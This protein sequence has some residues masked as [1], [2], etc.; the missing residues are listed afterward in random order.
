MAERHKQFWRVNP[1]PSGGGVKRSDSSPAGA[2]V[3]RRA[4]TEPGKG[5][6]AFFPNDFSKEQADM[7][8][9]VVAEAGRPE[10]LYAQRRDT[11][12]YLRKQCRALFGGESIGNPSAESDYIKYLK[13]NTAVQGRQA[14]VAIYYDG[15]H[16]SP[17][18]VME[19]QRAKRG[20]RIKDA[21]A[22]ESL[23]SYQIARGAVHQWYDMN[24]ESKD[25]DIRGEDFIR[26]LY[27]VNTPKL[28][29][30]AKKSKDYQSFCNDKRLTKEGEEGLL[31]KYKQIL[32][33]AITVAAENGEAF[34]MVTPGAFLY[35]LTPEHQSLAKSIFLDAVVAVAT[36]PSV[37]S[38]NFKGLSVN[39][40]VVKKGDPLAGYLESKLKDAKLCFPVIVNYQDSSALSRAAQ[41]LK[42]DFRCAESVMGEALGCVGNG[43]LGDRANKAFEENLF[44]QAPE[45][46][47]VFSPKF[48]QALQGKDRLVK[49]SVPNFLE[50][51]KAGLSSKI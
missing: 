36:D 42:V 46:V 20:E 45:L 50:S 7:I 14:E 6:T 31:I 1:V 51:A 2:P 43:G 35:G 12:Q 49:V 9:A 47:G 25:C 40:P 39:P 27:Y 8:S 48:N 26:T 10:Y 18:L 15:S 11:R 4:V 16:I 22:L 5:I 17:D 23:A 44:R 24:K 37:S 28:N 21:H 19:I 3:S 38:T 41:H 30:S 34:S 29:D 33:Q 13:T 32:A